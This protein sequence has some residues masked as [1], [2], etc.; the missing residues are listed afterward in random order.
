MRL[1]D[2]PI[3][4]KLTVIILVTSVVVM[5]L[6]GGAFFGYDFLAIRRTLVRQVTTLG[7]I[8]ATNS[9]AALAFENQDDAKEILAAFSAERN[10][11]AVCLYDRNGHLFSSY[12]STLG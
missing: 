2:I 10:I 1:A 12:P 3:R 6:M 9:T 7:E 4:R 8:A 5:M 11:V